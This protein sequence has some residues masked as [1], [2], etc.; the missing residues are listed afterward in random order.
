MKIIIRN[1]QFIKDTIKMACKYLK[2]DGEILW[3]GELVTTKD[4]LKKAAAKGLKNTIHTRHKQII[5]TP[6]FIN[7]KWLYETIDKS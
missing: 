2:E 4:E 3:G 6:F 1:K 5:V 7:N